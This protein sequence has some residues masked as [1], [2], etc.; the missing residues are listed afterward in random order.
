MALIISFVSLVLIVASIWLGQVL[1]R[2]LPDDHLLGD[3]KEVIRLA[4]RPERPNG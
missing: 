1:R 4:M 2:R 3:S